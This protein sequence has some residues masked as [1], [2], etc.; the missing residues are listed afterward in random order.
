MEGNVGFCLGE[1]KF[2][3]FLD[4]SF[5]FMVDFKCEIRNVGRVLGFERVEGKSRFCLIEGIC[6]SGLNLSFKFMVD[7]KCEIWNVAGS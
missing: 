4:L 1:G 7:S 5:K 2:V 3:I 6:L